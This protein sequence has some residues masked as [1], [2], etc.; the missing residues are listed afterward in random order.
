MG[1]KPL[2]PI[3]RKTRNRE[4]VE[5]TT[6]KVK[7]RRERIKVKYAE[8]RSKLIKT[9][10]A[11]ARLNDNNPAFKAKRE[12]ALELLQSKLETELLLNRFILLNNDLAIKWH[13]AQHD[14][15]FWET[16]DKFD[17]IQEDVEQRDFEIHRALSKPKN[18]A[19]IVDH[20]I[21]KQRS[22]M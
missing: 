13:E 7:A 8:L 4:W 20:A 3:N 2:E 19:R 21:A 18:L 9:V 15:P 6:E 16:V 10:T 22:R 5:K 17:M 14:K 1:R 12:E 11:A